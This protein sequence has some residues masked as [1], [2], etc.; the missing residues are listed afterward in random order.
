M[1]ESG[2]YSVFLEGRGMLGE[3][4]GCVKFLLVCSAECNCVP[5]NEGKIRMEHCDVY[6][7]NNI[8]VSHYIYL[9]K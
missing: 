3:T 7:S 1:T 9:Y 5:E 4:V 6:V 2:I 8:V